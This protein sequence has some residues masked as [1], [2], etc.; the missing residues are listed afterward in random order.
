MQHNKFNII[1]ADPPW[2]YKVYSDK[3]KG[4][5]A[6]NHYSTMT[7]DDIKNVKV[8]D[9]AAKDSVLILWVTSPCLPEGLEVM[10]A[11][12][13]SFKTVLFNWVKLNKHYKTNCNTKEEFEKQFR[14]NLGFYSR[15]N[16]ELCLLG[17]KGK[18]LTRLSKSIRQLVIEP[19]EEHSKKP[20]II[21]DKIVQL[22]GDVPRI[23]LFARQKCDGWIS[24]G[25][26]ITGNDINADM[27]NIINSI[28]E[29]VKTNN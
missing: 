27:E 29:S 17:T 13:F 10:K 21:R 12:G 9:I 4:R 25:N 8:N 2:S 7:I 1:L 16:I 11:W 5:S 20:D 18:P 26:A 19:M 3:G 14:M 28:N 15:S 24:I 6:E 23:E 22:F